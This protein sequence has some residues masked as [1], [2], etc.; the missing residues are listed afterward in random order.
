M[1]NKNLELIEELI[2]ADV[3]E[4]CPESE[5]EDIYDEL[6]IN[7]DFDKADL[8]VLTGGP[9]ELEESQRAESL[10][11]YLNEFERDSLPVLLTT[12]S[13]K[14]RLEEDE[15]ISDNEYIF[16]PMN[17]ESSLDEFEAIKSEVSENDKLA[18]F[19][20]D[21]HVPRYE[22]ILSSLEESI[23]YVAFG[24]E[25]ESDESR[26]RSKWNSEAIRTFLPQEAK[27]FGKKYLR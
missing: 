15:R 26:Y 2:F 25:F 6:F 14:L 18:V 17:P 20:N 23:D 10:I 21:Y 16:H 4:S 12:P 19:T 27:D 24:A 9:N 8:L 5:L 22:K 13:Q 1:V 11:Q 7:E 3:H